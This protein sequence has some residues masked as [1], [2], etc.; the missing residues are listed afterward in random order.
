[1][2]V[3][4]LKGVIVLSNLTVT[5]T[6]VNSEHGA[7]HAVQWQPSMPSGAPIVLLHDSLGCV[8]LWRDFPAQLAKASGRSVIAYD[9]LGFGRSDRAPGPLA[10]DFI[11]TEA[12][13]G[14]S[15]VLRHF[16]LGRF[17]ALGHSVG[18]SMAAVCAARFASQCERLITIAAQAFVE[19]RT[20]AGIREAEHTFEQPGQLARLEKYHGDKAQWVLRAWID[21]WTSRPFQG[22]QIETATPRIPCPL[23]AIHGECDEYGSMLHPQRYANWC[24]AEAQVLAMAGVGHVPQR[25]QPEAV[26]AAIQRFL[27]P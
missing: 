6:T 3:D 15:A 23:L 4:G 24:Q 16:G 7:L 9:R 26:L 10:P 20:L 1:M 2:A 18:G 27:A 11:V 5:D 17:V 19:D 8:A 21:T 14:F 25:E 22:W 12:T 13:D